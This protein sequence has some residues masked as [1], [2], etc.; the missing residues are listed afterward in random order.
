M[1]NARETATPTG[2]TADPR[3]GE[4]TPRGSGQRDVSS[5][6]PTEDPEVGL[7]RR[8]SGEDAIVR[9]GTES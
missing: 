9:R 6:I 2:Q 7:A 4:Q 3:G 8:G 1:I 5:A